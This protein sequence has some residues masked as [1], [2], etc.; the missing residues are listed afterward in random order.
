MSHG[1]AGAFRNGNSICLTL[2]SRTLV[3]MATWGLEGR[4][5]WLMAISPK[6][7]KKEDSD[8][9]GVASHFSKHKTS[10]RESQARVDILSSDLALL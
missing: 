2:F 4:G 7:P 10:S 5:V 8:S 3:S 9:L 6:P 1:N